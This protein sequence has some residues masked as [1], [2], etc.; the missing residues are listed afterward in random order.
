MGQTPQASATHPGR[1]RRLGS[2]HIAIAA[3]RG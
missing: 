1:E 3:A 2:L